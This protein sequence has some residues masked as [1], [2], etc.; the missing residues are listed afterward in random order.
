MW[1]LIRHWLWGYS[2]MKMILSVKPGRWGNHSLSAAELIIGWGEEG[3]NNIGG[4][5][6]ILRRGRKLKPWQNG[7][8]CASMCSW[9]IEE[10]WARSLGYTRWDWLPQARQLQCPV[11]RTPSAKRLAARIAK[12][13]TI[14]EH[15][16]PGDFA[17]YKRRGGHHIAI[18]SGVYADSYE[19][20]D[21]NKGRYDKRTGVGAKVARFRH[22][23]NE[24]NLLYFARLPD[25]P[26]DEEQ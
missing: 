5:I 9:V 14:V 11:K 1:A 10:G 25:L 22:Q 17:L 16:R 8:W 4:E 15:P 2:H 20:I 19:T 24:P 23:F 21:G 6:T 26:R 3:G 13:G 12:A 7:A 18:V